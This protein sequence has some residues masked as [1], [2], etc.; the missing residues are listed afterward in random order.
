MNF[1]LLL[2]FSLKLRFLK[3]DFLFTGDLTLFEVVP[4][5]P[6]TQLI[7]LSVFLVF[8]ERTFESQSLL[9]LKSVQKWN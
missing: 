9:L 4:L 1:I 5:S 6:S 3:F 7:L 8:E 2:S